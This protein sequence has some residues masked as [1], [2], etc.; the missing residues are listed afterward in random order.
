MGIGWA[1]R[2]SAAD[3]IRHA[4]AQG[5]DAVEPAL[6]ALMEIDEAGVAAFREKLEE[7]ELSCEVFESILPAD[8]RVTERGFNIY[9]W[10]E[11]LRQALA[12]ASMLGCK[13]LVWGDGNA[14]ILPI[15]GETSILKEHFNQFLFMF[16]DVAEQHGITVCLEPLGPRRTNFLNSLSEVAG[17]IDSIGKPNLAIALSSADVVEIGIQDEEFIQYGERIIHAQVEKPRGLADAGFDHLPFF[18]SLKII[19]YHGTIALSGSA[20][21]ESLKRCKE[22]WEEAAISSRD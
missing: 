19:A 13:T 2:I 20:D 3:E 10:T 17:T 15:E 14:R 11:Y 8:V 12:R 7:A 4:K 16:C 9:S 18:A 6:S 5:F 1:K 21:G 22:L